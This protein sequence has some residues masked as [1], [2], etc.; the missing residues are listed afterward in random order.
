MVETG[1]SFEHNWRGLE[2]LNLSNIPLD[3]EAAVFPFLHIQELLL[4]KVHYGESDVN[5][6]FLVM[7]SSMFCK[8]KKL[9]INIFK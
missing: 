6:D 8:K 3:F 9:F 7:L 2:T 4:P 1:E 5:T